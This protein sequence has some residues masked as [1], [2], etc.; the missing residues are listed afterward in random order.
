MRETFDKIRAFS[1]PRK[2]TNDSKVEEFES[3]LNATVFFCGSAELRKNAIRVL[4][5]AVF[6]P[7]WLKVKTTKQ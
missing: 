4:Y 2:Q 7:L 3:L 6:H 5:L 1:M